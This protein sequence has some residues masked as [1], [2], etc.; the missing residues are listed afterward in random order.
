MMLQNL[1]RLIQSEKNLGNII[2]LFT[3]FPFLM[4]S[5]FNVPIGDDFAY[6][7]SFIEHGFVD[8]QLKWYYEW[9]GRYMASLAISTFNPLSYGHL[10]YAFILPIF[11][12][13]TTAW[14]LKVLIKNSVETFK[15][16]INSNLSFGILLFL[17]FNYLPD[18]GETFYW[19]AGAFTYQLP[20]VFL[21]IYL[22]AVLNLLK[23]DRKTIMI[24]KD[25]L[26]SLVSLIII[27]G[28]NEVIV[29]YTSFITVLI[30]SLLMFFKRKSFW[31]LLPITIITLGL[32]YFMITAPGNFE[33][34][35]LFEK[36]D[37]HLLKAIIH[38]FFRAGFVLLFWIP[39]TTVLLLIVPRFYQIEFPQLN[40][41][42]L[43]HMQKYML[44]GFGVFI[45][46][47]VCVGFFPSIYTTN[48]IPKRSYTPI[49]FAFIL[50]FTL[51]FIQI[52]HR[53][54]VL[55][56]INK[57]LSDKKYHVF[58]LLIVLA[59]SAN[60]NVMKAYS[61]LGTGKATTYHKQVSDTYKMLKE[62]TK[63]TVYVQELIKKPEILPIRWPEK[64]NRLAN[65]ELEEYFKIKRIE[66]E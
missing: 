20:I 54:E 18:F 16:P 36:S 5:F 63:D 41:K 55:N 25:V 35:V 8:A 51:L 9:S 44:L 21:L 27:M 46:G 57:T 15:L 47:V 50:F 65:Q 33:R 32:A 30:G 13:I 37:F 3:V 28:S 58:L 43:K 53:F 39:V 49:F 66:I 29:V 7:S 40:L 34:A 6:A 11:L 26:V 45:L 2:V 62:T 4:L 24:I 59:L 56:K 17:Y 14:S 22:N 60:A 1:K 61:D 23:E 48:W 19:Y 38:T 52:L 64:K 10:G 42:A 12:I 31:R